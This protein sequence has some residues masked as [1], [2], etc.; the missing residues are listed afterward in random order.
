MGIK[1][2]GI[3]YPGRFE[4]LISGSPRFLLCLFFLV[5]GRS[6]SRG[7]FGVTIRN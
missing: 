6:A 1:S 5:V 4:I 3:A 2:S 7:G